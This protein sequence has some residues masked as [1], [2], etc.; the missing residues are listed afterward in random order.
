MRKLISPL[1]IATLM[2]GAAWA[3]GYPV[4]GLTPSTRPDGAPVITVMTKAAD[5]YAKALTGVEPPYPNSLR[6]LEDQGNWYSPF[7]RPGM[8]GPYDIRHWHSGE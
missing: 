5:W 2:A 8:I 6:F 1:I 7:L 3:E 4:A